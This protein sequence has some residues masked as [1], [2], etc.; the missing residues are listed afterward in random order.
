MKVLW[1][2]RWWLLLAAGCSGTHATHSD[3]PMLDAAADVSIDA[4][5][6]AAV[7]AAQMVRVYGNVNFNGGVE[8]VEVMTLGT[9]PQTT[10]TDANGDFYF[11]VVQGAR[12][13]VEVVPPSDGGLIPMIRGVVAE[14]HLRPRVFYLL[15]PPDVAAA[16]SLG[17]TFDPAQAIVETDFRNAAIG[18]YGVTLTSNSQTIVPGYGIVF[19]AGGNPVLGEQTVTGGDGST[20]L[21]G[22]LPVTDVSFTPTVPPGATLPCHPDDADPLPLLPGVATWFDFECGNGTD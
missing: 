5:I 19:D 10:T 6:D 1:H 20:L 11:D 16:N 18:G 9:S 7:D 4:P 12:L 3:A 22:G 2:R 21:L 17:I 8:G 15:G 14:D 13:I